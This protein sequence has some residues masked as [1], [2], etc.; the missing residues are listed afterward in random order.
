MV[1]EGSGSSL[2]QISTC[3][4]GG[5]AMWDGGPIPKALGPW[6]TVWACWGG[7][8]NRR[9]FIYRGGMCEKRNGVWVHVS[10]LPALPKLAPALGPTV[11][12]LRNTRVS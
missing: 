8:G 4:K 5:G 10:M 11:E 9:H 6:G 3:G 2:G 12:Q 1:P 7:M